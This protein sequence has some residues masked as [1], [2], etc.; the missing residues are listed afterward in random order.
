MILILFLVLQLCFCIYMGS[1]KGTLFCDEAYSYGL[2]NSEEYSFLEYNSSREKGY[3]GWVTN[4][5]FYQYLTVQ[6][7]DGFSLS[8]PFTNQ[9]NDVHPP[10]YY[11]LLHIV[12]YFFPNSFSKWLGIGLNLGILLLFD[13]F[14]LYIAR[15]FLYSLRK[16]LLALG[17]WTVSAA[18]ISTILLI[19]MYL[20][21]STEILFFVFLHLV[22]WKD[23]FE[24][25]RLK[26]WEMLILLMSV[27]LGGLTHYYFYPFAAVFALLFGVT[28]LCK[29]K[30]LCAVQYAVS[31]FT[32][33]AVAL[34]IFPATLQHVFG[35]YRGTQALENLSGRAENVVL[36]YYLPTINQSFFGG[37][38]LLVLVGTLAS[39][40]LIWKKKKEVCTRTN[41][42]FLMVLVAMVVFSYIS[43]VGSSHTYNRYIYPVYAV[44]AIGTV[45][46]LSPLQ[47]KVKYSKASFGILALLLLLMTGSSLITY[48][49]EYQYAEFEETYAEIKSEVE[50]YDCIILWDGWSDIYTAV[51]IRLLFDETL[52]F[53]TSE[54]VNLEL[55][56]DGRRTEN[57]VV[58]VIPES[59]SE[60]E[61]DLVLSRVL[62]NTAYTSYEEV[63][64]YHGRGYLLQ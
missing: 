20:L 14:F 62:E 11:V 24:R 5:Y 13:A 48:G 4:E 28:L 30:W 18:G 50:G 32:G 34:G 10:F 38:F 23:G 43:M 1:L 2:A 21:L 12:C 55:L 22:I 53:Q 3:N 9:E 35:G 7:E 64:D 29:K 40:V 57:P 45:K 54:M 31:L 26:V 52:F 36:K 63:Y 16:A 47:E 17:M 60:D 46:V 39:A 51:P 61:V 8:A 56:L 25:K 44:L 59:Y 58:F 42:I 27:S 49:V 37:I 41:G 15:Y 6:E 19:R 33:I